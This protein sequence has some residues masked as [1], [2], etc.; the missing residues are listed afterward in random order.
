MKLSEET[1][2]AICDNL[3]AG[4]S[5]SGAALSAGIAPRTFWFWIKQSQSGDEQYT[6][7]FLGERVPFHK[8]VNGARRILFHEMRARFERRSLLGHTEKVFF[9]GMPTWKPD[10][11]CVGWTE[12]EREAFGFRR[13]GLLEV[14]GQ[15]IQNEVEHQPPVAAVL[16]ALSVGFPEYISK[17][18]SD[19]TVQ[20]AI[21][22]GVIR[23]EKMSGPPI[24]PP[25]PVPPQL[26]VL[27]DDPDLAELLGEEDDAPEL[28]DLPDDEVELSPAGVE[29]VDRTAV[30]AIP[31][32]YRDSFARL[33]ERGAI[34]PDGVTVGTTVAP[35][36]RAALPPEYQAVPDP[37]IRPTDGGRSPLSDSEKA[38]L[39]RMPT[40]L[41]RKA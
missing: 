31:A 36:I 41:N 27:P 34:T 33:V 5:Y 7:D 16:H 17:S 13:D 40:S 37:L 24:V 29:V 19:V 10:P 28:P 18:K 4:L 25:A 1:M 30:A 14:D 6:L 11:R 8:A 21:S 3:A 38:L 2:L 15:V 26:E 20:G 22:V 23:G 35:V 39:Q 32:G 9:S 12:D